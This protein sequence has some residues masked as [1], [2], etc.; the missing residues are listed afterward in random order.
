MTD[1]TSGF[2]IISVMGPQSRKLLQLLTPE[3]LGNQ[4][5]PFGQSREI[6]FAMGRVR[7]SRISYVG[8]LGWELCIPSEFA[9]H[10]FESLCEEGS[11][12]GLKQVGLYAMNS[13]RIEKG[14]RH[15]GH[16]I[17]DEDTPLE[18]GLGF[19]VSW[20]KA[21][22]FI[23]DEALKKQ[24]KSGLKKRL[25]Q[26]RLVD[27][28]PLLYHNEPIWRSNEIVGYIA[29]GMYGH[30]LGGAVGL[31]YV[32]CQNNISDDWL[33]AGNYSIEVAGQRFAAEVSLRPMYDP[34]SERTKS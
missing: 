25:A 14:F 32:V 3:N 8:E 16:D 2:A 24:Q 20:E 10:V 17:T 4:A 19:A 22:G 12:F 23:G 13:L 5:F 11:S 34:R 1:V 6:E 30:T 15:W 27:P 7:A 31:G 18:A 26:F 21:G 29:S 28:D 33:L 9:T